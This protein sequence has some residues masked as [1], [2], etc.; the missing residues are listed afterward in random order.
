MAGA[1]LLASPGCDG[2]VDV[3]EIVVVDASTGDVIDD[4]EIVYARSIYSPREPYDG[5]LDRS[6]EHQVWVR[7]A[8][9]RQER[10]RIDVT[11]SVECTVVEHVV[12]LEPR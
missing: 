12:E 3:V 8:G 6:G 5:G 7:A 10:V 4:P 1:F 11:T 9:Y 2:C